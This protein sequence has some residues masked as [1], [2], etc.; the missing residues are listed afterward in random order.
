MR[1]EGL[2]TEATR[3]GIITMLKDRA[4]IEVEK[5]I[6]YATV[7]AKILIGSIGHEI[8]AS[9][10]MTAKWEQKLKEISEGT[11]SPK[12]FMEQTKKMVQYLISTVTSQADDWN[13]SKEE[14]D[15]FT[16][17][18]KNTKRRTVTKLGPC[19]KCNGSVVDKGS[20]YGCTNYRSN[21]C[22]FT[23]SKKIL[24][25]NITQKNIKLLLTEGQTEL[26][27]GF[28]GKEKTFQAKLT[29]D[30][31]AGKIKF[32]FENQVSPNR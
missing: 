23:I 12:Q 8:L 11:A 9:P 32:L 17:G 20:F 22:N 6:V 7:K 30:Q 4:Y 10:E 16:P 21:Q 15:D 24:G 1:T 18:K 27:E 3:A 26:I 28:A 13:F 2:G 31:Q 19:K 14:H 29:W 5:N 25:K